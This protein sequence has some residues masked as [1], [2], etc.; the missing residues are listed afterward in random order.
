M[1]PRQQKLKWTKGNIDVYLMMHCYVPLYISSFVAKGLKLSWF[2]CCWRKVSLFHRVLLTLRF[3]Y[4]K[5]LVNGGGGTQGSAQKAVGIWLRSCEFYIVYV[6]SIFVL[7]S[8]SSLWQVR[9]GH[10][11]Y[12]WKRPFVVSTRKFPLWLDYVVYGCFPLTLTLSLSVFV[13]S[14]LLMKENE[15]LDRTEE[16]ISF[17]YIKHERQR[18]PL[19][20]C[21]YPFSPRRW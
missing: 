18:C 1:E 4:N 2:A 21:I 20:D 11:S 15:A 10:T 17:A 13:F 3:F 19:D 8:V 16:A 5:I 14:L 9:R 6:A 12:P 7:G